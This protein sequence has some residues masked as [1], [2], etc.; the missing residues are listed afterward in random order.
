MDTVRSTERLSYTVSEL[1]AASGAG[2][3]A[4]YSLVKNG[5][6]EAVRMGPEP[7][8]KL[9]ITAES[10]RRWLTPAPPPEIEQP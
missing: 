7:R 6:L 1:R 2:T 3:N 5:V 4:I 9:L 10:A 8:G